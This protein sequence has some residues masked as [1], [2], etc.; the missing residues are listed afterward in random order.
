MHKIVASGRAGRV[1]TESQLARM[2][3]G[4]PQRRYNLVNRALRRGDLLR[5][6]RGRYLLARDGE[7]T[8]PHPFVVAQALRPGCYVSFESALAFHGWIPESAPVTLSVVPG[9]RRYEKEVPRLG[10]FRFYPLSLRT[11]LFLEGADR[12][13]FDG[14]AALLAQP[15]RAL[16]DLYC[17]RKSDYPGLEG[18]REDLRIDPDVLRSIDDEDLERLQ[19]VYKHRRM[20]AFI[21]ALRS[22]L[23]G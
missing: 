10:L 16:L 9:R 22:E 21:S 12:R 23:A 7:R 6:K 20:T 18:V 4:T 19:P 17:R 15:L 11:G 14:Q 1:I 8:L 3:T 13:V 5:L 2:L